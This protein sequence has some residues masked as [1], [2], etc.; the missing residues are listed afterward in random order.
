MEWKQY[1]ISY[2]FK[3]VLE[4][5][6]QEKAR[7]DTHR[8]I[9]TYKVGRIQES[10]ALEWTYNSNSIEGNTLS[11]IE[12]KVVIEDGL[13]VAGKSLKEHFEVVNHHDAIAFVESLVAPE[14]SLS[15]RDI[16][17]IH[18]I[19]L[20]KI[21]RNIAGRFRDGNVRITGA[22]FT[23]PDALHVQEH[24]EDLIDWYTKE[25]LEIHPIIKAT[26]F[27]HRFVWIHPFFDGN[28]RTA[29]LLYNL[30]LMSAG[31]P[32]A[33]ILTVDRKKYYTALREGDK[34]AYT[35]LFL[36]VG[37]A[38]E[39]SLSIYISNIEGTSNE[40]KPIQD[41]VN[42]PDVPYGQE[43]V[44]LLARRGKIEAYKEGRVWYTRKQAIKQYQDGRERKRN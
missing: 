15:K 27:H 35:K 16:L 31:Y 9:P 5:L 10:L 34:G 26:I 4:R 38:V 33:I 11:L 36:L 41:I 42:E 43:Y 3:K 20:D 8:P 44:S 37:Q 13:T 22:R 30:L 23:P 6:S 39:R 14:Y 40:F 19:V 12:T 7:L 24:L 17:D 21:D 32:P 29:R 25:A 28:G 2:D 18:S 1:V